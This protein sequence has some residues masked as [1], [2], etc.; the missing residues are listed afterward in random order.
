[1]IVPFPSLPALEH[2]LL[3]SHML[4]SY[5]HLPQMSSFTDAKPHKSSTK[6]VVEQNKNSLLLLTAILHCP[7]PL[8]GA[9]LTPSFVVVLMFMSQFGLPACC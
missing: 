2:A 5:V 1:M 7:S 4:Q 9:S 6:V 3:P 8:P